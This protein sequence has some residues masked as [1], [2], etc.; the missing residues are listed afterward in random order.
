MVLGH[1][2]LPD[3]K[4]VVIFPYLSPQQGKDTTVVALSKAGQGPELTPFEGPGPVL[5]D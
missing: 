3:L 2:L 4:H 5:P 1:V